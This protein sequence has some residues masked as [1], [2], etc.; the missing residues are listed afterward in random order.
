MGSNGPDPQT[1]GQPGRGLAPGPDF[2]TGGQQGSGW[3]PMQRQEFQWPTAQQYTTDGYAMPPM[4]DT[5]FGLAP[6]QPWS[7]GGLTCGEQPSRPASAAGQGSAT[8]E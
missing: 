8:A 3:T 4:M 7:G 6:Y 1:G 2:S 5:P